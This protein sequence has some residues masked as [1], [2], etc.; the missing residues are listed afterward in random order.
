VKV[1]NRNPI[2]DICLRVY[3]AASANALFVLIISQFQSTTPR[4]MSLT[5]MIGTGFS[6]IAFLILKL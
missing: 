6:T 2:M 3:T 5:W 1:K 4:Q